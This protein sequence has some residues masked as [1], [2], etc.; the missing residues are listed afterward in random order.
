VSNRTSIFRG[1][2]R[3]RTIELEREPGLPDGQ[4]VTVTVQAAAQPSARGEGVRLSAG[5][6]ADDQAGLDD[7]LEWNRRRRKA[8]RGGDEA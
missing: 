4:A 1:V 5:A 8:T 2:V 7:F 6:W 3:G